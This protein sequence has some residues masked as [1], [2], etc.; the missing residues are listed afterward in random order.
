MDES[1]PKTLKKMSP[2]MLKDGDG[3]DYNATLNMADIK[4][5]SN[6][7]CIINL[8]TRNNQA[9]FLYTRSGRVGYEGNKDIDC[10]LDESSAVAEFRH[11]FKERTGI[12]WDRRFEDPPV[13]GKYSFIATRMSV[14]DTIQPTIQKCTLS[15]EIQRLIGLIHN[16]DELDSFA[17][18]NLLDQ[19]KLPLG[20][21]SRQQ[22]KTALDILQRIG[23]AD[24]REE[25]LELNSQFYTTLPTYTGS[26]GHKIIQ[27]ESDICDKQQLIEEL[28]YI[29]YLG[30]SVDMNVDEQY[31]RLNAEIT[32]VDDPDIISEI[33]QYLTRNRGAT[34]NTS[35]RLVNVYEINKRSEAEHFKKYINLHNRQL[36]WHG[37]GI[38]NIVGILSAG[39]VLNPAAI[40]TGKMFGNGIYFANSS[41]KS[42]GYVRSNSKG[43]GFMFLC[44]VAL[45]TQIKAVTS[46]KHT[47]KSLG[48]Y[49]SVHGM[50]QWTPDLET[51]IIKKDGLIIPIGN[52]L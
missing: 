23:K 47:K 16:R 2:S 4:V 3:Y 11:Q 29:S 34:H 22:L 28:E 37:T 44:E 24:T 8:L 7:S 48:G 43:T 51:H 1:Y 27:S 50:G 25:I 10:F 17:N 12:D 33:E 13:K 19:K 42:F 46:V 38:Q 9:Y 18:R 21:L 35:F 36:L 14:V 26:K 52:S 20:N 6:K 32:H 45:G 41:S 15:P 39:L 49:H 5:N 40:I 31:G 30:K